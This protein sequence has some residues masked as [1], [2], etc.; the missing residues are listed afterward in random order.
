ML[1]EL[2]NKCPRFRTILPSGAKHKITFCIKAIM[3]KEIYDQ[4]FHDHRTIVTAKINYPIEVPIGC[5]YELEHLL[6][7]QKYVE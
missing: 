4:V 2:C 3:S 5:Q 6:S 7:S 1:K